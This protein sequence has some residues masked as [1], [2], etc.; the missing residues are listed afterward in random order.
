MILTPIGLFVV[1]I[2][3]LW[4]YVSLTAT[5]VHPTPES[6]PTVAGVIPPASAESAAERARKAV[7]ASVAG[8]NLP[9]VSVAVGKAG[10]V[11]W[12][13]GFG[14]ADL[15]SSVPVKP[16][17]RF[18][19]GT[20]S[21]AIASAAAGRLVE[22][23]RLQLD[24]EIQTYVP[25][26]PRKQW[27]VTV[28]DL[29]GQTAGV[30][31]DGGEAAF[32]TTHCERAAEALPQFAER[33]LLFQPGTQYQPSSYGW[34]VASAA[35]EAA[36]NEPFLTVVQEEVFAK[37]GM[38][39]TAPDAAPDL[40]GEDFPLAV[41]IRELI[42]DPEAARDA[43]AKPA[44]N[45]AQNR[46]TAYY[47]RFQSDPK[48]GMH[49]M[50][51]LDYSCMAGAG[52]F[53]STPSDLVRF[54]LAMTGGGLLQPATVKALQTPQ[55]LNTGQATGNGLGWYVKTVPVA[56]KEMTV[57]GQDGESL[58]G[59]VATLITIPELGMAVAVISNISHSDTYSVALQVAEAFAAGK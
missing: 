4:I 19:I 9:G 20:A 48:H 49:V 59:R 43:N 14:F 30:S 22:E 54:G 58:G 7:R 16:S 32:V 13:E 41:M 56:G 15:R 5:P 18:R 17:H 38:R 39:D 28:R 33:P 6:V 50:R 34:I 45:T 11:V 8:Q 51:P 46:V 47:T 21:V 57:I 44:E 12:A 3:S 1:G 27:P 37:A 42:F 24:A 23:G 31:S 35:M 55:K 36:A 53:V 26:F 25:S 29:M 2:P 52:A 40:A 10:E